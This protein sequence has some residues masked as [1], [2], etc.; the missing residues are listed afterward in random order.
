MP[1]LTHDTA[2]HLSSLPFS[3]ART[4][5]LYGSDQHAVASVETVKAR[6]ILTAPQGT[7]QTT[8]TGVVSNASPTQTVTEGTDQIVAMA[9]IGADGPTGTFTDRHGAVPW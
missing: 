8:Y 3:A 9:Q 6:S 4:M 5:R 1:R 2:V 7:V